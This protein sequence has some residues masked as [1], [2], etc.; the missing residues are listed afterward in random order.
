MRNAYK[1]LSGNAEGKRSLGEDL[2]HVWLIL[3]WISKKF[4]VRVWNG[5]LLG[6][7]EHGNEHCIQGWKL[8]V[9]KVEYW[10]IG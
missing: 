8:N 7:Y 2:Y 3:E 10:R 5:F 1:T 4:D 6:S 9:Q